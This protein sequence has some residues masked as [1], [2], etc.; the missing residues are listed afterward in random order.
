VIE[1]DAATADETTVPTRMRPVLVIV[2]TIAGIAV[3][4]IGAALLAGRSA[5]TPPE[6]ARVATFPLV[7]TGGRLNN[8]GRLLLAVSPDGRRIVYAANDHLMLRALEEATPQGISGTERAPMPAGIRGNTGLA[9]QPILSPDGT[10]VAYFQGAELKRVPVTGGVPT[11]IC[12][13]GDALGATWGVDNRILYARGTPTGGGGVWAVDAA[14]GTPEILIEG[15]PG[16]TFL[17]PQR[18]SEDWILF[19]SVPG[20]HWDDADIVVQS[21][22]MRERQ[23]L[24]QGAVDGRYVP[25]GH[26]LFGRGGVLHAVRF[27]AERL[28]VI[29]KPVPVLPGVAQ[30]TS[31][32]QWG[33]FEYDVADDGTLVYVPAAA[34][35]LRRDVIWVDRQGREEA[36][37]TEARAYQYPRFSPDGRFVAFDMRDQLN[38]VWTWDLERSTLT[39]VTVDR[40]SGGPAIWTHDGRG[41]IFGPDIAGEINLHVQDVSGGPPRRLTEGPSNKFVDVLTSDG[42]TLI[43]SEVDPK[44]RSDLR[45]LRL[46]AGAT[47]QDLVKTPFA[48]QNPHISPDGRWLAYQSD[49]SGRIEV[50][51]RPFPDVNHGRWQVSTQGGSRPLWG[52]DGRELFYLDASRRM[53]MVS[54]SQAGTLS[55]GRPVAMFE[56]AQF[57]LEG[58]QRNFD[59]APDGKRFL[60]VKN[61]PPPSDVPPLMLIQHWFEDLR[62][63]VP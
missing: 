60:M 49:E 10:Q 59:L 20:E 32:G 52:R 47:P 25:S 15:E 46:T 13:C 40:R 7:P 18:L 58:Q 4:A 27:D 44:T 57:G 48:E 42:Q 51:V 24:L 38:D 28:Q 43:F 33:G 26:L 8:A 3:G 39:R 22:R 37:T 55:F 29:G 5:T 11:V 35:A 36:L 30:K 12:A 19:T 34:A 50:Y 23:V 62:A 16:R 1:L 53:T 6:S 56:T 61:L 54:V 21:L 9:G 31:S 45:M 41:I 14:G 2:S 17:M 63:K